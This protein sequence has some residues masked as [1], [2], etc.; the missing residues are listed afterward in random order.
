MQLSIAL[1]LYI[2]QIFVSY[3][4]WAYM[5]SVLFFHQAILSISLHQILGE[6][7]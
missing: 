1:T 6:G 7:K 3:V 5:R 2:A 4:G